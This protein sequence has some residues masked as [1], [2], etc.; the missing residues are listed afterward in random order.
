M[1]ANFLSKTWSHLLFRRLKLRTIQSKAWWRTMR[2]WTQMQKSW[3][4]M[5]KLR[6]SI[7]NLGGVLRYPQPPSQ[8]TFPLWWGLHRSF[9]E[10]GRA[11]PLVW[12]RVLRR[13]GLP[14]P[15]QR[16]GVDLLRVGGGCPGGI[17]DHQVKIVILEEERF[18]FV[19]F[20][21]HKVI[22]LSWNCYPQDKHEI[23]RA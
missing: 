2:S 17:H 13:E 19:F 11:V 20:A 3:L 23:N 7:S 6:T 16:N 5:I 10:S 21:V 4:Q 22:Y 8:A 12:Q 9:L 14:G 15:R 18:S 1:I